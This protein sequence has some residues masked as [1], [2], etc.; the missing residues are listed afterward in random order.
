MCCEYCLHVKIDD[1]WIAES[2]LE[3]RS[4]YGLM[5]DSGCVYSKAQFGSKTFEMAK[6]SKK[7][8]RMKFLCTIELNSEVTSYNSEQCFTHHR[9][10]LACIVMIVVLD[11]NMV[12]Q[13]TMGLV[14]FTYNVSA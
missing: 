8:L 6:G 14:F 4:L 5:T 12:L 2:E 3:D 13:S 9:L 1:E 10:H 7:K 11:Q